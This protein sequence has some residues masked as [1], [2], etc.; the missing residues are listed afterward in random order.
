MKKHLAI[1][2]AL[3]IAVPS[4]VMA[5]SGGH[6]YDLETI[7]KIDLSPE[8]VERGYE[9]F[10]TNC[11]NCHG[12]K[13]YQN[14]DKDIMGGI[15]AP[16]SP[17]DAK[18]TYGIVPPDLSLMAKAKGKDMD[19]A[20]YIYGFLLG[21]TEDEHGKPINKAMANYY[22]T[23]GQTAMPDMVGGDIQT[24]KDV[25]SFLYMV[26][27]PY[28]HEREAIGKYV[29]AFMMFFTLLFY[30]LN[31]AVWANLDKKLEEE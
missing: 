19:G 25:T 5:S 1:F 16:M 18:A 29:V 21:F 6:K 31:K 14:K 10:T 8:A 12:L 3:L 26:A 4:V 9:I 23:D 13:Y 22:G 15:P 27:D 20:H 24:A 2:L 30:L 7:D 28:K 17:E 11:N